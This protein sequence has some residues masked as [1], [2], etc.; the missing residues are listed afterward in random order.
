MLKINLSTEQKS[1]LSLYLKEEIGQVLSDRSSLEAKWAKWERQYE[2][3]PEET[4][5]TF[6]WQGSCNVVVPVTGSII[7]ALLARVMD[8]WKVEPFFSIRSL[9]PEIDKFTKPISQ[10]LEWANRHELK[11]FQ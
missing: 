6:P 1:E 4:V 7:D 10:L 2:G 5:K 8:M 3:K 9:N 11:L